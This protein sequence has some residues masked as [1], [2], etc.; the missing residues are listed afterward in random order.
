MQT[1]WRLEITVKPAQPSNRSSLVK[2]AGG[3]ERM[4]FGRPASLCG[5]VGVTPLP[6]APGNATYTRASPP[7][8]G[9][10]RAGLKEK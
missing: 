8:L 10:G 5:G 1:L 4:H 9:E 6:P 2:Q 7:A 3:T